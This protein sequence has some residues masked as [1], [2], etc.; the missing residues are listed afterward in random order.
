M[1]CD[2]SEKGL[3]CP[4][5]RPT[6]SCLLPFNSK[7]LPKMCRGNNFARKDSRFTTSGHICCWRLPSR[8]PSV[9]VH[10]NSSKGQLNSTW[11]N[12]NPPSTTDSREL[13]YPPTITLLSSGRV[14]HCNS[15]NGIKLLLLWSALYKKL[16]SNSFIESHS[17]SSGTAFGCRL[18]LLPWS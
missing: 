12:Y 16:K 9:W 3:G 14:R 2:Q 5:A 4:S 13:N 10:L 18:M 15:K 17:S 1:S 6:H 8:L 11:T 7:A